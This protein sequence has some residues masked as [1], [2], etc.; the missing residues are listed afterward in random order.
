MPRRRMPVTHNEIAEYSA[1]TLTA[2]E[3]E[4]REFWPAEAWP[5][6]HLIR[7][8][9]EERDWPEMVLVRL[10]QRPIETWG[11]SRMAG[12]PLT[13]G[14]A[15]RLERAFGISAQTFLNYDAL[16]WR[17]LNSGKYELAEDGHVVKK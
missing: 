9:L 12:E 17:C 5:V 13:T 1:A 8:M 2:E 7:D 10:M 14:N 16:F 11:L 3:Q 6:L 4:E 15:Q